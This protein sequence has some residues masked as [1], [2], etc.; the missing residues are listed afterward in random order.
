MSHQKLFSNID[1]SVNIV[2]TALTGFIEARFVRKVD[3]YIICYLSSQTGCNRGCKFC[4]LTATKQTKLL[5]ST[6]QD[7]MLQAIN[8][9]KHYDNQKLDPN[10]VYAK[11]CHFNFMARGEVLDNS[12][13]L[14]E[15]D[16]ILYDLGKIA[17]AYGLS[18]KFNLS[19]IFPKS[20]SD[21]CLVETFKVIHPTIYWSFY[22]G[23][24]GFRRYWMPNALPLDEII[25][26][27]KKYQAYSKKKI[28]IHHCFIEGEND[29]VEDIKL[30]IHKLSDLD[31]EF[32][33]VRYNPYSSEQGRETSEERLRE[34]LEVLKDSSI[35]AKMIPRVGFD[36]K[37]SCG[38]FIGA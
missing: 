11:V 17:N 23:R 31:W 27:L 7:Y 29:S 10:F 1:A 21:K 5:N 33:L 30:M 4:H 13:F 2:E 35:N 8:V 36:V 15:A 14:L 9:I 3:D 37:A 34:L 32:N 22:S 25:P 6:R 20:F 19:T 26:K 38:T 16:S 24:E 28:K 18:S 12:N